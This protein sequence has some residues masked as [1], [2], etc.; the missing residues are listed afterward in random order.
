[1]QKYKKQPAC[2]A[3]RLLAATLRNHSASA[4]QKKK[5]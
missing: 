5:A 4:E 1:M 3:M 2:G